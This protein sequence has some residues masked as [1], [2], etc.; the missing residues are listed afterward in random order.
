MKLLPIRILIFSVFLLILPN[1]SFGQYFRNLGVEDGLPNYVAKCFAQDDQGFIW[2]GTFNGL[3]RYDG[4][5]FESYR[6]LTNQASTL[7]NN[8]IESLYYD[9]NE[10]LW[11]GT[12]QG[13][14][15][16]STTTRDVSHCRY[17][18]SSQ[19]KS[20]NM[21]NMQILQIFSSGRYL[22]ATTS[23]N[24][25]LYKNQDTT[26]TW[27][28]YENFRGQIKAIANYRNHHIA[29]LT[30]HKLILINSQTMK[31]ESQCA[32]SFICDFSPCTLYYSEKQNLIFVGLGY[33]QQARA[34][35]IEQKQGHFNLSEQTL[36]LPFH[37]KSIIDYRDMT[38]FATDGNGLKAMK[39][40]QIIDN[41]QPQY[42]RIKGNAIHALFVDRS[43][44]L[45][46]GTY[47]EGICMY[48]PQFDYFRFISPVNNSAVSAIYAYKGILYIGTDGNG[49]FTYNQ[50]NQNVR[51][52][53][54]N[55]S[56]ILGNNVIGIAAD[57]KYIWLGIYGAGIFKMNKV[58][59][60]V[61]QIDLPTGKG[62]KPNLFSLWHIL[63]DGHG[64]LLFQGDK[65]YR[66]DKSTD[67][68]I[69]LSK[70]LGQAILNACVDK[71]KLWVANKQG[72]TV[73]DLRTYQIICRYRFPS[74]RNIVALATQDNNVY[75]SVANGRC[76]ELSLSTKQERVIGKAQLSDKEVKSII[77]DRHGNLWLGT[78]K[79]LAQYNIS[80]QNI[81]TYN[82]E[83]HLQQAQFYPQAVCQDK[84]QI[85]LGTIEGL[86]Y[87]QPQQL[88]I[89]KTNNQ[90]FFRDLYTLNDHMGHSLDG[91]KP[92]ALK[93][94]HNQNFFTIQ[95]AVPEFIIP[96]K[97]RFRYKLEGFDRDWRETE[98]IR[99]VTYTNVSPGK[100][101]F[102]IQV[103]NDD[104]TWS[105][106][107]SEL[108]IVIAQ[109][110][111]LR[112]WAWMLWILLF[113]I[114]MYTL[115]KYYLHEQDMKHKIEQEEL[116][117]QIAQKSHEDKL[118]F[119]ANIT[120]ELRTP[121]FL[122]TAP[123]EELLSSTQRPVPVPY[124]YLKRMY[125]NALRLN[126]LVNSIIDLRKLEAGSLK[127][128]VIKVDIID[129]CKRLSVDYRALC[130][131]KHIGFI[132][133]TP[134]TSLEVYIDVEKVELILSNLVANAYKYT[135]EGGTVSLSIIQKDDRMTFS[136]KDTGIGIA[137][138]KIDKIFNQ[139]Y[140]IKNDNKTTGG[141]GLGLTFVKSL[142]ELHGGTI[143]VNSIEG[144]GSTFTVCL[145]LRP[146]DVTITTNTPLVV[147]DYQLSSLQEETDNN[148]Q[149]KQAVVSSSFQ[150]P[151]A[152]QTLLIIDDEVETVQI[153]ER[154]LGK[155]YQIVTA[156]DGEEG[157][158]QAEEVMPDLV[159]CDVMMPRMD[160]FEFLGK[161]KDNKRLQHI[162]VIMFTAKILDEDKIAAFRYGADA[163]VTKPVSLK[164][165]QARIESL[166]KR[167]Q[168]LSL[169]I[170]T[171]ANSGTSKEDQKF[172]L[173]CKEIIDTN[174]CHEDFNVDF[175]ATEL[176]MSHSALYKKVK[177]I[178]GKSVVEMI[179]AY[180]IFRA[181]EL[182][183]AGNTNIT[184]VSEQCGFNDIRSFRAAFKARIGVSPKQ[185]LQQQ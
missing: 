85:F 23:L 143:S 19:D 117:K 25:L 72:L 112:W 182:L 11:I 29:V 172:I 140:R 14:D 163:Y 114:I 151:T 84:S 135:P 43:Q 148:Q 175:M 53:T 7:A 32:I 12:A 42:D 47:R 161:F 52:Y 73:T 69:I 132:F 154:F 149:T 75:Y 88:A 108:T 17:K 137:Q 89:G 46:T 130:Q 121:M 122:I 115:F 139:Y 55:N 31:E 164:V 60:S 74:E 156:G 128:N 180:R 131:Q 30:S 178:T 101:K 49:F 95:F 133:Y 142:V 24:E 119:F 147:D 150:S 48:A 3:A 183:R 110:W 66:Y 70:R 171:P 63:D 96:H 59:E 20:L 8:H 159:I 41:W 118:N 167:P 146:K 145:P 106:S 181:V 92:S 1:N 78:D 136:I 162:P 144:K 105:K 82:R 57:D 116:E 185:F 67:K 22:W 177:A 44:T 21:S 168:S 125:R 184:Q 174:L 35:K 45:W 13:I 28:L 64:H 76:Y 98:N 39:N 124:T 179:V 61:H 15:Y 65:I 152:T 134:I 173:R 104:N 94:S 158:H 6:H 26:L 111:Y 34:F 100:Y 62:R 103:T 169:Q 71:N 127:L 176:N 80:T 58:T 165:L 107:M 102:Y 93:L 91:T 54:T 157:L 160:G 155:T 56:N 81:K 68:T 37:V 120:H 16:M 36:Q 40:H 113:G 97:L 5:H 90:V 129:F 77:P 79:G 153:L 166:L 126:K 2:I 86:V 87:F 141:D 9:K 18:L 33:G 99:A 170:N 123:L 83:D 27:H 4:Y 38:L 109:P 138:D 10:G 50:V 51:H